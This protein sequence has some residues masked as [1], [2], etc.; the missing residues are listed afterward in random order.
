MKTRTMFESIARLFTVKSRVLCRFQ[1]SNLLTDEDEKLSTNPAAVKEM[2][3]SCTH[4]IGGSLQG[5][6]FED[7]LL[8]FS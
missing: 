4:E 1:M 3:T 8:N 5:C 6:R 2:Q 7:H